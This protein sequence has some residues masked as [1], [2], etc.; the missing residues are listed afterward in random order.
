VRGV[1]VAAVSLDFIGFSELHPNRLLNLKT[2]NSYTE[3]YQPGFEGGI[4][5]QKYVGLS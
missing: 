3:I 2:Q 4:F 5:A 1:D